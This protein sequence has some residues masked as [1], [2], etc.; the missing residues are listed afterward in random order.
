MEIQAEVIRLRF[1][2]PENLTH[3]NGNI[4]GFLQRSKG[5]CLLVFE[6]L[7]WYSVAWWQFQDEF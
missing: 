5:S 6:G 4:N 2:V 1:N 7:I 3:F